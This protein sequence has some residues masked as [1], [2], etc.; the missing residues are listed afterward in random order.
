MSKTVKKAIFT[1]FCLGFTMLVLYVILNQGSISRKAHAYEK[2][3]ERI[4]AAP[5]IRSGSIYFN[6][7]DSRCQYIYDVLAE[8]IKK[9][10]EFTEA[11]PF[12][13]TEEELKKSAEAL[14]SDDP[15]LYYIDVDGFDL[16]NHSYTVKKGKTGYLVV[17]SA[18]TEEKYTTVHIPYTVKNDGSSAFFDKT[19]ARFN[20]ALKKADGI[21]SDVH[22]RYLICRLIH[23]YLT[24][25]C[26]KTVDGG[27]YA[28][29]AYGALVEGEATSLG[30]A[31]AFK[32][33]YERYSGTSYII[34]GGGEYWCAALIYDKYYNID[35][36]EDDLDGMIGDKEMRG[37]QSHIY[38][39][40][41][42]EAFYKDRPEKLSGPTCS[43]KTNYFIYSGIAPTTPAE[44]SAVVMQL[45]EEQRFA[46]NRFFEIYCEL[47]DAKELIRD[48]V[49]K[50]LSENFPDYADGC[51]IYKLSDNQPVYLIRLTEASEHE[52][53]GE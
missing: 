43:D 53:G 33:L 27:V 35:V 38:L 21:V 1:A 9:G 25:I 14:C 18:V 31:K 47:D 19:Q 45:V 10:E 8:T 12:V 13:V 15:S 44:V 52:A 7:L 40:L 17:V 20:A 30:Y 2:A 46:K 4:S 11:I 23:D 24:G 32:L 39:C 6:M 26:T 42:D 3:Q 50:T 34:R 16:E 36:Y 49:I 51:E 29:T 22:D 41:D 5:E 28:D 48:A 37:A